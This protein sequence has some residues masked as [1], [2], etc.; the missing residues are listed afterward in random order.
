ME[1]KM[2]WFSVSELKIM[3]ARHIL[4][5]AGIE[6]FIV[7]KKDSAHAGIFGDIELYV[8]E[9]DEEKARIILIQEE[10]IEGS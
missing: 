5:Q 10:I 4:S 9:D 7:D 3:T 8:Q 6:N 1:K 2:V